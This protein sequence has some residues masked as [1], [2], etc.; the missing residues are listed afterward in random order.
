MIKNKNKKKSIIIVLIIIVLVAGFFFANKEYQKSKIYTENKF[1]GF[2]ILKSKEWTISE[3]YDDND[4][5]EGGHAIDMDSKYGN[6]YI[7][8][9][10]GLGGMCQSFVNETMNNKN[11]QVCESGTSED[12]V[13]WYEFYSSQFTGSSESFNGNGAVVDIKVNK[14]YKEN[15]E[16]IFEYL[17]TLDLK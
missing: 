11:I 15:S 13:F 16:N 12:G 4:K 2:S 9:G 14:P 10:K 7:Y 6:I 17:K 5:Q 3:P 8:R 1:V